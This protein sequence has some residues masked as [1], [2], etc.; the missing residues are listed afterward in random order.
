MENWKQ[1]CYKIR[2]TK[3]RNE[4]S[5]EEHF[6]D[7]LDFI[8]GWRGR[9]LGQQVDMQLGHHHM[10][11]DLVLNF[12][13]EPT[14]VLEL[15][16]PGVPL[17]SECVAQLASYMKHL[18]TEFGI[19][20][21]A[22]I[23][24]LYYRSRDSR[25]NPD[26]VL[27]LRFNEEDDDGIRLGELLSRQSYS[28]EALR[29]F[30]KEKQQNKQ[31]DKNV[32]TL[33]DIL[34]SNAGKNLLFEALRGSNAD[35]GYSDDVRKQAL[36]KIAIHRR[37]DDN[38]DRTHQAIS[39]RGTQEPVETTQD[40]S[41][42]IS[43]R[44]YKHAPNRLIEA[45]M[46]HNLDQKILAMIPIYKQWLQDND[47]ERAFVYGRAPAVEWIQNNILNTQKLR[48]LSDEQYEQ[49]FREIPKH[50]LNLNE[51][52]NRTM[53]SSLRGSKQTFIRAIEH[54][55]ETPAE[56]RFE[57]I[58]DYIGNNEAY[59]IKGLAQSF[60]SEIIRCRFLDVPLVNTKTEEFFA[61]IGLDIGASQTE[62]LENVHYCYTRWGALYPND[63]SMN[64][65]SHMEHF[66][67]VAPS[68]REYM[69][70]VFHKRVGEK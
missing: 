43:N 5:F 52:A 26:N 33:V 69:Q 36:A 15:K 53:Y 7:Y 18:G 41:S 3:Y 58:E 11:L 54:L 45:Q 24:Q 19:L 12:N 40:H 17:D 23:L 39:L 67:K 10:R 35:G 28:E 27:T 68:G 66:A 32:D 22:S 44:T 59:K 16:K 20:T 9:D 31:T 57:V 38:Y 25:G 29:K 46:S 37:G 56:R 62:K 61:T 6:T 50:L 4:A 63:I 51:G 49:L 64:D 2:N 34:L 13:N 70:M 30:C 48:L 55:N 8:F 1:L 21:N 14:I 60:W 47:K 42:S 65:F